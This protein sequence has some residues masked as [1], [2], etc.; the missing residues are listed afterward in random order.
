MD[1]SL[2]L[3]FR[4]EVSVRGLG[5]LFLGA[6]RLPLMLPLVAPGCQLAALF[7]IGRRKRENPRIQRALRCYWT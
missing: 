5:Q 4:I 7:G 1:F 2:G 6:T 3:A